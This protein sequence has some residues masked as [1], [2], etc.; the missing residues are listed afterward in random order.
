[1]KIRFIEPRPAGFNV[2]DIT[3]LPRLGLPLVGKVLADQGHDVRVYAQILAPVDWD[4]V[5]SAD[6]V[7]LSA[8]TSTAPAAYAMADRLRTRGV[9]VVLGG[10]HVTFLPDEALAH[11]DFVVRGEGQRTSVE[12]VSA[13]AGGRALDSVLGLSYHAA[14]RARHNPPRPPCTREEFA[15]LP[16]PDLSLVV[17][18]ERMPIVPIMTQWGCPFDCDFCSVIEMFGRHVR[19]RR[20]PDVLA[21]LEAHRGAGVFFYDDNFVVNKARTRELLQGM[22]DRRLGIRWSAQ[23][24]AE[25]VYESKRARALDHE[26]LDLMR[27]AGCVMVYC[28][29]ESVNP[30]TL[31]A[32]RKRQDVLTIRDSIAAF[33]AHGIKV[34]GMFVVG[35][36]ADDSRTMAQT[37]RFALRHRI[38]T[39]QLLMLTPCPGTD[40]YARMKAQGRILSHDWSL[41]DGHHALIHPARMSAYDLQMGTYR[42]M[43]RFYSNWQ[44]FRSGFAAAVRNLPFLAALPFRA[45]RLSLQLPRIAV[46]SLLPRRRAEIADIL[47]R[48]LPRPAWERLVGAFSIAGLRKFGHDQLRRWAGQAH[49]LA[50]IERTR[51]L[52]VHSLDAAPRE[53]GRLSP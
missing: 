44:I 50:H 34:H 8:L 25:T 45:P 41:Y 48:S 39:V 28:G 18:R 21:E 23:V 11:A 32:Y 15:A 22:I 33:H 51:A 5:E 35:S 6:L 53:G 19:A 3:P 43:L 26:L 24:R 29:Y 40:F 36:D 9:P 20:V 52:L 1:M 49:S 7:G 14:G 42:A 10:P 37:V 38:D 13:L 46:L 2:F 47:R 12:L 30:A 16:A 4:D 27:A 31:A 17:G